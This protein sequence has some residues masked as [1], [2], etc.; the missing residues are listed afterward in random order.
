LGLHVKLNGSAERTGRPGADGEREN[1]EVLTLN[2][3]ANYLGL[4]QTVAA[5]MAEPGETR[6][7][8]VS[9][10]SRFL[11]PLID[12]WLAM[13]IHMSSEDQL[14]DMVART[15]AETTLAR[16]LTTDRVVLD[17]LP[18]SKRSILERLTGVLGWEDVGEFGDSLMSELMA[19]EAV[20]STAIGSGIALPHVSEPRECPVR[21]P[22][23][24]IGICREG[25]DFG[26]LDGEPTH[27]FVLLCATDEI[28][29]LRLQAQT[30]LMLKRDSVRRRLLSAGTAE[31]VRDVILA[32][33]AELSIRF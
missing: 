6:G 24:A 33:H 19:R 32:A 13:R 25:T 7:R 27:I 22:C 2:E 1:E 12:D 16:V 11:K 8:S 20:T 26:A 30:A 31:D 28:T 9:D 18:G 23:G 21:R 14:V 15:P 17:L 29:H 4:P 5:G 3:M 10:E